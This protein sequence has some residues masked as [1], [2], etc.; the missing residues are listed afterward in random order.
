MKL[1]VH[2]AQI[3]ANHLQKLK[4]TPDG[5]GTLLD[6]T[7]FLYGAC[8][9]DSNAHDHE[10]L[11]TLLVGGTADQFKGDRHVRYPE[12]TPMT[13]LFLT[14]AR[15]GGRADRLVREQQRPARPADR[16]SDGPGDRVSEE[17]EMRKG[18]IAV[19]VGAGLMV[20][21]KS[22][23]AHHAFAAEFDADRPVTLEGAVTRVDWL[24]PHA[25]LYIDVVESDG[26]KVNWAIELAAPNGLIRRGFNKDSVTD[27]H[28]GD[29][30]G[31]SGEGRRQARQRSGRHL[32]RRPPRVRRLV[33]YR[34]TGRPREIA[35]EPD[36]LRPNQ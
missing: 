35:V 20:L 1:H 24:N 17:S 5:D 19:L 28:Q 7:L 23:A 34:R 4:D 16:L 2:H 31:V 14:D 18:L 6:H 27:R 3:F 33:R 9:S 32:L 30:Q 11:P 13:N 22:T 26:T 21:P 36:C 8:L 29:R 15:Q 12:H 25:W 10:N